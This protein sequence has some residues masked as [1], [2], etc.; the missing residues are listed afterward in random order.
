M[1]P[2]RIPGYNLNVDGHY[3]DKNV[4]YIPYSSIPSLDFVMRMDRR[5]CHRP[6][7]DSDHSKLNAILQG[8]WTAPYDWRLGLDFQY[9]A[10]LYNYDHSDKVGYAEELRNNLLALDSFA[11]VD[12][13]ASGSFFKYGMKEDGTAEVAE[14]WFLNIPATKFYVPENWVPCSGVSDCSIT[15][16]WK[17]IVYK[18]SPKKTSRRKNS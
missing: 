5:H 10:I 4:L 13:D 1:P 14:E 6:F 8:I 3:R 11:V 17:R 2:W 15:M 7:G 9:D 12:I 16:N 18:D